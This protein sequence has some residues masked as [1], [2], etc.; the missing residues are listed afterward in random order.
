MHSPKRFQYLF[1]V[2]KPCWSKWWP[3][4]SNSSCLKRRKKGNQEKKA[5]R[6]LFGEVQ[7]FGIPKLA[8]AFSLPLE[9]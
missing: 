8:E 2:A 7:G 3:C 1:A 4:L 6:N 5:N 9:S